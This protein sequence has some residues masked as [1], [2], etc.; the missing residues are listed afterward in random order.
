MKRVIFKALVADSVERKDF[1][2]AVQGVGEVES[3]EERVVPKDVSFV[4]EFSFDYLLDGAK[5]LVNGVWSAVKGFF[6][7]TSWLWETIV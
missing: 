5:E 3:Y 4:D 7:L 6:K 2:W 1:E